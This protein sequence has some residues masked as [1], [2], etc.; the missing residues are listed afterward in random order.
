MRYLADD[1]E[2]IEGLARALIA[3]L[4]KV[5]SAETLK[6]RWATDFTVQQDGTS[7]VI[8]SPLG[9]A[10]AELTLGIENGE[11]RGFWNIWKRVVDDEGQKNS[12][13]AATI[14]LSKRGL[15]FLGESHKTG[16]HVHHDQSARED[17]TAYQVMSAILCVIGAH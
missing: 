2:K 7:A 8:E 11:V 15:F 1:N 9:H 10:W 5:C 4:A 6:E 13:L 17:L 14:R 12:S 3:R 16:L